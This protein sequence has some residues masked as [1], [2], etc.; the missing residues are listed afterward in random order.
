ML[1]RTVTR[2]LPSATQQSCSNFELGKN[3]S[4]QIVEER[5]ETLS[6]EANSRSNIADL[7]ISAYTQTRQK[8]HSQAERER[9]QLT[10]SNLSVEFMASAHVLCTSGSLRRPIVFESCVSRSTV[11]EPHRCHT[12]QNSHSPRGKGRHNPAFFFR[13]D[14]VLI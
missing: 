14:E 2:F 12:T 5:E 1:Y 10:G 4:H 3:L 6:A 8:T 7:G 11:I 9:V 13:R